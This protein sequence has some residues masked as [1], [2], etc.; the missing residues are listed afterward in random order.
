MR[1]IDFRMISAAENST[2]FQKNEVSKVS[3]FCNG[4]T[5]GPMAQATLVIKE[6]RKK[7]HSKLPQVR[8]A[9][10]KVWPF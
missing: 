7:S 3:L 2:K 4:F 9:D 5:L 10:L 6:K 8:T 1:D